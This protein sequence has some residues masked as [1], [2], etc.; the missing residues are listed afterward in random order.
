MAQASVPSVWLDNAA[1]DLVIV[2]TIKQ[3]GI[4]ADFIRNGVVH[5]TEPGT[6]TSAVSGKK[7]VFTFTPP[8]TPAPV[9]DPKDATIADLNGKVEAATGLISD[10]QK[11]AT[12]AEN[13]NSTLKAQV[14]ASAAQIGELTK[15]AST[16][17]SANSTL[18]KQVS[19]SN[20]KID[21]LK[22]KIATAE[23]SLAAAT[24][25][26]AAAPAQSTA[27]AQSEPPA[28]S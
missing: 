21:E 7:T 11:R 8:A 3:A 4:P 17:E 14:Y 9:P 23:S 6:L 12:T 10:L 28:Q 1:H 15:R 25:T 16:A 27:P 24:A 18:Q 13:L 20:A 26:P 2:N 19:T 22:S 5:L